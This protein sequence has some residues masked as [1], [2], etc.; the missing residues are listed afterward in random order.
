MSKEPLIIA[1]D[2]SC[3]DTS[4]AVLRGRR[5]LSS[6]VSSQVEIHA[7]WGGVVPDIARREHEKNI[8]IVYEEALRK[9]KIKIEDVEYIACTYG[10]GLA[11]DLEVGLNFAKD[12][13][14]KYSKPFIPVNHMEGHFLSGLLL[15]SK[16]SGLVEGNVEELFPALGL[17]VSGK[18]TDLI[19]AEKIAS[20]KKLGETLDDAVGEAFDKVGR[21]LNFGY[22]GGPTLTEFAKKGKSGVIAFTIPMRN[23]DDLNFSYSGVKTA[24]LYKTKELREIYSKD[25]EWVYDFCRGFLDMIVES[26]VIKLEKAIMIYPEVKSLFVGGG[27]FNSEEILR[28]VGR[29]ARE[30]NLNFI[31]SEKMY[32]GDNAGMIGVVAYYKVLR[33]EY[34]EN[35]SDISKVDREPRLSF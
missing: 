26:L 35:S 1:F 6:V 22:P 12:L 14:I 11:I 16:G 20:Y 3:D 7:Q 24:A 17:L 10:P 15:N 4:V 30:N 8:P 29:V 23:S 33:K 34:L 18:H 32:R 21:M 2:T 31:Y 5:V 9:A 19:Y 25:R 13:A 28:K 27:V